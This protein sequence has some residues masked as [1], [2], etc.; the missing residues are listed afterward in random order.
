M[1]LSLYRPDIEELPL[2]AFKDLDLSNRYW[3]T[4]ATI[5]IKSRIINYQNQ[6]SEQHEHEPYPEL[7]E[8]TYLAI[9]TRVFELA[10]AK[11]RTKVLSSGFA[12]I[13]TIL[14]KESNQHLGIKN[15]LS[16]ELKKIASIW[17][18]V[19]VVE[20]FKQEVQPLCGN[21]EHAKTVKQKI[22]ELIEPNLTL[23]N[24]VS[25]F[26]YACN[27]QA[28][29]LQQTCMIFMA[30]NLNKLADHPSFKDLRIKQPN[31]VNKFLNN[32]RK[33]RYF[34]EAFKA[35]LDMPTPCL[36]FAL[37]MPQAEEVNQ[38]DGFGYTILDCAVKFNRLDLV[39]A[40]IQLGADPN[41]HKGSNAMPT[42]FAAMYNANS[43]IFNFI[44]DSGFDFNIQYQGHSWYNY[45]Q[46]LR[47]DPKTHFGVLKRDGSFTLSSLE[48]VALY[49][50]AMRKVKEFPAA[51][52]KTDLISLPSDQQVSTMSQ[53]DKYSF[54]RRSITETMWSVQRLSKETMEKMKSHS[55]GEAVQEAK[56]FNI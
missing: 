50:Q 7:S 41:P 44:Y 46:H 24:I 36:A 48:E 10:K 38:L 51:E 39:K 33:S 15:P 45:L 40:L 20:V 29:E 28:R 19:E 53:A 11:E 3:A 8:V 49:D 22:K 21:P 52:I 17:H 55:K 43:E 14:E 16:G 5:I 47:Q 9:M 26:L 32:L 23:E 12:E 18:K 35:A 54:M 34:R 37:L 6:I 2:G 56:G 42:L 27:H 25:I 13:K 30:K 4:I 1:E 31:I